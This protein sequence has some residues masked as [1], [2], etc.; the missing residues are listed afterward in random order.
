MKKI[1]NKRQFCVALI[2]TVVAIT[3]LIIWFIA[4]SRLFSLPDFAGGTSITDFAGCCDNISGSYSYDV[5]NYAF[6]IK[7]L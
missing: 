1:K 4:D 5:C 6:D 3:A 2:S 7:L